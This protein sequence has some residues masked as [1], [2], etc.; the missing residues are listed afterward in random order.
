M[1]TNISISENNSLG[2]IFWADD[3]LILSETKEGLQQKLHKLNEYCKEN[4]LSLNTEK[5]KC[6]VFSKSGRI[7]DHKFT[8][9]GIRL[10]TVNRYKYLGFLVSSSGCL[11][12]GLE[13]LRIRALKG[14][15]S[16]K[17]TLGHFFRKNVKNTIHLYN[18]MVKPIM[19]YAS[20]FWGSL[21]LPQNNPV[22]KLHNVL[23]TSFGCTKTNQYHK[24]IT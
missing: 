24:R 7:K 12:W 19:L 23:Q 2:S 14:L 20:D 3:I 13:D 22:E 6:I 17:N 15:M 10:E 4:K 21:K 9:D 8:Y 5:T 11:K 18:T 1:G 16:L